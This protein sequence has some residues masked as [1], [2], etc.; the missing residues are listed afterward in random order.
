MNHARLFIFRNLDYSGLTNIYGL[1]IL[2]IHWWNYR[3]KRLQRIG[4]QIGFD[5]L[6]SVKIASFV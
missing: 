4:S 3:N 2:I 5:W 6:L 1:L